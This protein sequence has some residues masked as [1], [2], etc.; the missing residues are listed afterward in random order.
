MGTF[1]YF[2]TWEWIWILVWPV[3]HHNRKNLWI[4]IY[5]YTRW[6]SETSSWILIFSWIFGCR[7]SWC[8]LM[9]HY[10]CNPGFLFG[11]YSIM[12]CVSCLCVRLTTVVQNYLMSCLGDGEG[13]TRSSSAFWSFPNRRH[14]NHSRC[15]WRKLWIKYKGHR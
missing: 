14:W 2:A 4:P 1:Y 11:I 9:I 15:D 12:T 10:W 5:L 3:D 13:W 7:R 8:L 6:F